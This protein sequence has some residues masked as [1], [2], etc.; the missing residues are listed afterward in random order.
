[1]LVEWISNGRRLPGP[2]SGR[3]SDTTVNELL[4]AYRRHDDGY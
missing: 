1:M 2:A 4:L 3:G